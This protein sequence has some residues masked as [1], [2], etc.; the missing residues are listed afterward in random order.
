MLIDSIKKI[1]SYLSLFKMAAV[2]SKY[3]PLA[4]ACVE[5]MVCLLP[6]HEKERQKA[7]ASLSYTYFCLINKSHIY[8]NVPGI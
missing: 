1:I 7:A 5:T 6:F 4:E 8:E 3:S 2:S